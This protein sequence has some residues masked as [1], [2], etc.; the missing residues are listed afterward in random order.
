[1]DKIK[2]N[3]PENRRAISVTLLQ[4][5]ATILQ[6][7]CVVVKKSVLQL[8][9]RLS[10][11]VVQMNFCE[12]VRKRPVSSRRTEGMTGRATKESVMKG[13]IPGLTPN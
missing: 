7:I 13:S 4:N 10:G 1:M 11:F 12:S 6:S 3:I 9:K 8:K 5:Y 2:S